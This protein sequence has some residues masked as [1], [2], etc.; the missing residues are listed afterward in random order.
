MKCIIALTPDKE[1]ATK[2][3][4][5]A[6]ACATVKIVSEFLKAGGAERMG[7]VDGGSP[8]CDVGIE[9]WDESVKAGE[10]QY[11]VTATLRIVDE[12]T[13]A[14][15]WVTNYVVFETKGSL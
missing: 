9:T 4:T 6:K 11:C 13:R 5:I 1:Y 3:S 14:L 8:V 10:A 7:A 15:R 2:H 12:E